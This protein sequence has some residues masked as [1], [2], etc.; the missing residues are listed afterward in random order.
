M[1]HLDLSQRSVYATPLTVQVLNHVVANAVIILRLILDHD[2]SVVGER[3][4]RTH[5]HL[6]LIYKLSKESREAAE[7]YVKKACIKKALLRGTMEQTMAGKRCGELITNLN[8]QRID[9]P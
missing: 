3:K 2:F 1:L 9:K 7:P 8:P 5:T 4:L 6:D